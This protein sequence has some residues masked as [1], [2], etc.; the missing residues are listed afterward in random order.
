MSATKTHYSCAEL[1]AMRLPQY[2]T[3]ERGW[4]DL[5][6]REDWE[7]QKRAG[8]GGGFEYLPSRAV[9][10]LIESRPNVEA[11]GRATEVRMILHVS[12]DEAA[13]IMRL[14]KRGGA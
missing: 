9:A 2:P 6:A 1:A 5:V 7:G 14:L 10:R 8:R 4:R 3:T 11:E 12:F 13:R